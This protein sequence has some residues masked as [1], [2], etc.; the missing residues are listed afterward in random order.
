[1]NYDY[2]SIEAKW[3]TRWDEAHAFEA[4]Q[5]FTIPK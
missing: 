1:M 5:D 3:Q 4:K 2:K